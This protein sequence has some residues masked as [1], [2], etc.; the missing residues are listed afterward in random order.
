MKQR[1]F[2]L[3]TAFA[4][5]GAGL[6]AIPVFAQGNG[7]GPPED[8]GA[9]RADAHEGREARA[10]AR[11]DR[12]DTMREARENFTSAMRQAAQLHR[13]CPRGGDGDNNTTGNET[14]HA[15]RDCHLQARDDAKD[16][17][18]AAR[19]HFKAAKQRAQELYKDRLE[20]ARMASFANQGNA[21][22]EGHGC[23]TRSAC[24]QHHIDRLE[25]QRNRTA[26][27]VGFFEDKQERLESHE[28]RTIP[29]LQVRLDRLDQ[30]LARI[31]ARIA[32]WQALLATATS[33]ADDDALDGN[34]TDDGNHT[35][36][37][38]GNT[39]DDNSTAEA[40][41]T[42]TDPDEDGS[43]DGG[44]GSDTQSEGGADGSGGS[45]EPDGGADGSGDDTGDPDG[46]ETV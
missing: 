27:M 44:D 3:I 24:I 19:D 23:E 10:E 13:E 12:K 43:V 15:I 2:V 4:L 20:S 17:R 38:T 26:A 22:A 45:D 14:G 11:E 39:T 7:G 16:L 9:G 21:T 34:E 25:T 40:S 33:E 5:I 46:N 36:D 37:G 30:A 41:T 29:G 28:N 18:E 35:D 1:M 8:R 6:A 31:D 42:G 32:H